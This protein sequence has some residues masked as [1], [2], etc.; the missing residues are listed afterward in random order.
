MLIRD[1]LVH[2]V[3]SQHFPAVGHHNAHTQA[4]MGGAGG[5]KKIN[6]GREWSVDNNF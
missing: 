2:G 3:Y 1:Y 6:R 4:V 5:K